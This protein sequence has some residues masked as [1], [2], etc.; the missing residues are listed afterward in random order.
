MG[1]PG[2]QVS[3]EIPINFDGSVVCKGQLSETRP[4]MFNYSHKKE[5][6]HNK[7]LCTGGDGGLDQ[8]VGHTGVPGQACEVEQ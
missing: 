2:G 6:N 8:S 1:L 5:N 3:L 7:L 4:G